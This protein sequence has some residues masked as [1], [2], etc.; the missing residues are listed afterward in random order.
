[1]R[2]KDFDFFIPTDLIAQ[3]PAPE[4]D[5][6]R[7]LILKR[8]IKQIHHRHFADFPSYL[9]PGDLLILNDSRVI[10]A[11]LHGIKAPSGRQIEALLLEENSVNDWWAMLRPGKRATVGTTISF[12][13]RFGQMS[14]VK[15]TVVEKNSEGHGR[16][17]FLGTANL[18]EELD[19]LGS[20][21]LPPYITRT[22]LT[23]GI[24]DLGRYQTV[25]ARTAG[26]VAAPTAG[27]H[28]TPKLLAEIQDGGVAIRYVTLHVGLGTFAPVKSETIQEHLMHEE[29]FSLSG[30][31]AQAIN[32]TK[33]AGGRIIAVGTTS[34]RVLESVAAANQGKLTAT[35]GRTRIF[36]YPPHQ[37]RVID[38]LITNFHLPRS[39]LLMLASAF[40][41]P[42]GTDGREI[43]LSAYEAAV[44]ERYRF[45]S[46]GDAMLIL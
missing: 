2:T 18:L 24:D 15:A 37:F 33:A 44:R 5:R 25:F 12:H 8:T 16:L 20:V 34:V 11:R 38:A 29:R 42:N 46:Y 31:T 40:A 14:P 39:T 23:G 7:L 35:E 21:P 30:D 32:E 45:F 27:L 3:V 9:R 17:K 4:R 41:S 1:M 43:I 36:I 22:P 10:P 13:D 6:S 19:H 26:S 28:F